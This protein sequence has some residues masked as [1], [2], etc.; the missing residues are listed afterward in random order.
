ADQVVARHAQPLALDV[1]ERELQRCDHLHPLRNPG[2]AGVPEA[3]ADEVD[4]ARVLAD[5]LFAHDPN[6]LGE[7]RRR[8]PVVALAP[9]DDPFVRGHLHEEPVAAADAAVTRE[10]LDARD[11]H[12]AFTPTAAE[13]AGQAATPASATGGSR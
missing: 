2:P 11:L 1:V 13:S 3:P 6:R 7:R 5:D 12:R 9:A 10:R 4:P 8:L